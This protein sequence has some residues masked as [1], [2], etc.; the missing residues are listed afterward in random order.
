MHVWEAAEHVDEERAARLIRAQF[1]PLPER[2][3][4][5]VSE[6]WDYVVH[7]V[8]GHW[9]FRF[10][11]REVVIAGTER[12]LACLPALAEVLP[13]GIPAPVF[14]GAPG[15]GYPWPFYG[16]PFLPGREATAAD[17][18]AIARPLAR[19]L[20]V[21]H[22]CE[23]DCGLPTDPMG[24]VDM[25]VRVPRT[26]ELLRELAVD[27]DAL[28]DEVETLPPARHSAVCHGDLHFRQL[29]VDGAALS[30][31][32]DWIDVCRSDPA[33]D[34]SI[35][36]SLLSADAR[37]EFF[38]EY[39]AIDREREVRARVVAAFL[40]GMLVQWA[41]AENVPSVRDEAAAGLRRAV[42]G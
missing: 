2:S 18:E 28:L 30:G 7:L 24:R 17:G 35:A 21:L 39:G 16:A 15:E 9:A 11:R 6:G 41:R 5:L 12:E 40:S 3:V 14:V 31:I 8:D 34:L 27:A 32:V 37:A 38:D 25:R 29:L 1:A 33:V 42:D 13:V 22:T 23:L 4:E 36:W 10:P 26:R 19:A 20:R